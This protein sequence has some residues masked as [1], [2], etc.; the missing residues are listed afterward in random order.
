MDKICCVDACEKIVKP[1]S[2]MCQ[3]HIMRMHRY[4]RLHLIRRENGAGNINKSGYIDMRIDGRRT[5]EHIVIA[6]KAVGR[7]LW[8]GVVVHHVNEIKSDNRNENLV[9]C[10]NESYH[11]L[12]HRRSAAHDA[13]GNAN[14]VRCPLCLVYGPPEIMGRQNSHKECLREYANKRY[15]KSKESINV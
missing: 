2:K 15:A 11:R 5:Y 3:M 6:E 9:V 8:H 13:C 1:F 7:K 10:Q 12:L 4:G 14:Y